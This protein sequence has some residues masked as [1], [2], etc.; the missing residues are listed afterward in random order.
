M[1]KKDLKIK[2]ILP[3]K[4]FVFLKFIIINPIINTLMQFQTL[5]NKSSIAS[6]V[7]TNNSFQNI[8]TVLQK[9]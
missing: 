8:T 5:S 4:I 9:Q 3:Y 7:Q 2:K 6:I 1:N